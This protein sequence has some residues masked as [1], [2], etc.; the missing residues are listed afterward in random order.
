MIYKKKENE[1]K[2]ISQKVKEKVKE[3]QNERKEKK[4][5]ASPG[6]ATFK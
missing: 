6:G 3:M 4:Y 1:V 2:E 5:R